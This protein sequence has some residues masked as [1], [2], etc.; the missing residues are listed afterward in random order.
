[1]PDY[2][3]LLADPAIDAVS[4]CAPNF[5]HREMALAAAAAGKPF[6]IEK[7]MGRSAAESRDI[8]EG[9]GSDGCG[10]YPVGFNYRHVPAIAEARRLVRERSAGRRSRILRVSFFADYSADPTGALTW[11]FLEERAGS[12]V[13]GDL[14][15]NWF[16]LAQYVAGRVQSVTAASRIF[17]RDR[18]LPT[19]GAASHFSSGN[20]DGTRAP[21]RTR[22]TPP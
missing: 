19:A 5:L 9:R 3:D 10:D 18:P 15:S 20:A 22:T 6:W 16:D 12:G 17:I 2:R 4:I 1:M 7:P 8:A 11:R 14:L 13:M 21:S